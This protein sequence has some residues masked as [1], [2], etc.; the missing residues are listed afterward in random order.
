MMTPALQLIGLIHSVRQFF[1]LQIDY[2]LLFWL[3]KKM[4]FKKVL[5]AQSSLWPQGPY[6]TRLLCHWML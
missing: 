2:L 5:V 6:P 1:F 4:L 3:K